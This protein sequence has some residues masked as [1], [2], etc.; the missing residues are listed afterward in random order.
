MNYEELV[1]EECIVDNMDRVKTKVNLL[2]SL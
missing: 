1:F 2:V